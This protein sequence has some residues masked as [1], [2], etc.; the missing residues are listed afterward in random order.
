M[1]NFSDI[2]YR[3][4][5]YNDKY[6]VHPYNIYVV[7][8][9]KASLRKKAEIEIMKNYPTFSGDRNLSI[10]SLKIVLFGPFL[11]IAFLESF[12]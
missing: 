2:N 7:L 4:R 1:D 8:T 6:N 11:H 12:T 10:Y 5:L 9:L 3:L